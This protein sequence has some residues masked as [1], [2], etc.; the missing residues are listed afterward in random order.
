MT[1]INI[2]TEN[3]QFIFDPSGQVT[4]N[5]KGTVSF[6]PTK[7]AVEE[8]EKNNFHIYLSVD[9][10]SEKISLTQPTELSFMK[11]NREFKTLVSKVPHSARDIT[12]YLAVD[13][14]GDDPTHT[15]G[16]IVVQD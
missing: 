10:V 8:A 15:T 3:G 5:K 6:V 13:D 4:I 11:G 7:E 2:T 1:T 14:V 12:D 9:S 16:E